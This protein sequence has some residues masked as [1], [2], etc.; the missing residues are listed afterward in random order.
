MSGRTELGDYLRACRAERKPADVGLPHGGGVRRTPGLRREELASVA[1]I[2]MDYYTRLEQGRE[3]SPS[4][5]VL[6]SLARTLR[7]DGAERDH[8]FN[9][10]RHARGPEISRASEENPVR[11]TVRQLLDSVGNSPAYVLSHS[12]DLLA[13]NPS[14]W[15]LLKGIDQW[16]PE[17]RNSIRYLF[18]HPVAR[19]LFV[20]WHDVAVNSVAQL[21]AVFGDNPRSSQLTALVDELS[22]KSE[23]FDDIWRRNEVRPRSSGGKCFDHPDVGRMDLNYEVLTVSGGVDQR[24]VVYQATPGTPDYDA[25][26]LL[27]LVAG[28]SEDQRAGS[29]P[30]Y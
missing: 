1:G 13:A 28:D 27:N 3:R 30:S 8:L 24:L 23:D 20:R 6:D 10:A 18:L 19:T 5:G 12:N 21:R 15:L 4:N 16:P 26:A 22:S 11:S 29:R 17:R 9:L 14:G 2:S 25:M 7:L